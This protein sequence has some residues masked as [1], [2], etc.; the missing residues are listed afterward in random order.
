MGGCELAWRG[1]MRIHGE[2]QFP[3][4]ISG[5]AQ[6]RQTAKGLDAGLTQTG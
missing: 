5:T 1:Q 3:P 2:G 6:L 4:T